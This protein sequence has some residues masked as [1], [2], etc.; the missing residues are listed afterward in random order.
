MAPEKP[1]DVWDKAGIIAQLTSS[2][3]IAALGIG[4]AWHAGH[5]D[6]AERKRE[7][8]LLKSQAE[9]QLEQQRLQSKAQL[10]QQAG[11]AKSQLDVTK[12]QSRQAAAHDR[13]ELELETKKS[14]AEFVPLMRTGTNLERAQTL[15]FLGAA[16]PPAQAVDV[17]IEYAHPP[18]DFWEW[19]HSTTADRANFE[20]T[21]LLAA[22]AIDILGHL[23]QNP[24]SRDELSAISKRGEKPDSEI[25]KGILRQRSGVWIRESAM[26]D[27][28]HLELRRG[29]N[30]ERVFPEVKILQ[31]SGWFEIT[32]D[33]RPGNNHLFFW[34][35]NDGGPCSGRL[36][37]SVGAQQY[38]TGKVYI[39]N[40]RS[41]N[42]VIGVY[43]GLDVDT[44]GAV[45]LKEEQPQ[46]Q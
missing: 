33:L 35:H 9:A 14:V 4:L 1:K 43:I 29:A 31:D 11:E 10:D 17:A 45:H 6:I 20:A 27:V 8:D 12:E 13:A 22:K 18:S 16:L 25:A 34:V 15:A 42:E 38:D 21:N 24:E 3:V 40:C 36:E 19:T 26:D 23:A 5:S 46:F 32:K 28:G 7:S 44:D 37:L 39:A 41:G 2:I 30:V